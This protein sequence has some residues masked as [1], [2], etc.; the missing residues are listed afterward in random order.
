MP[1]RVGN[2]CTPQATMVKRMIRPF[3]LEGIQNRFLGK[4]VLNRLADKTFQHFLSGCKFPRSTK[5]FLWRM[6]A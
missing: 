5:F 1:S 4:P 3:D 2:D 6:P